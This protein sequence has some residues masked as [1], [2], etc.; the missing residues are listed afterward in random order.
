LGR[1]TEEVKKEKLKRKSE[2]TTLILGFVGFLIWFA[3]HPFR[4]TQIS[5]IS[6]I[7]PSRQTFTLAKVT[8]VIDGDTIVIDTGQHIRYIGM[9]APELN[10][11]ECN[12]VEATE[13]DK[14]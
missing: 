13:I 1:T 7:T 5:P 3:I 12:A 6:L 4:I 10:P 9:N 11:L 14:I 2:K 8:R